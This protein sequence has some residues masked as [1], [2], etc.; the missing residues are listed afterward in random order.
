[1]ARPRPLRCT[2]TGY[3]FVTAPEC[4][5]MTDVLQLFNLHMQLVH[6]SAL[7]LPSPS[8]AGTWRGHL[9]PRTKGL[10]SPGTHAPSPEYLS[11]CTT[12]NQ[13]AFLCEAPLLRSPDTDAPAPGNHEGFLYLDLGSGLVFNYSNDT[14]WVACD[15]AKDVAYNSAD[16]AVSEAASVI[17]ASSSVPSLRRSL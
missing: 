10:C 8:S 9:Q 12:T 7:P 15:A 11:Q 16:D 2:V 17:E 6:L 14:C 1:M 3:M 4:M 5:D 13:H